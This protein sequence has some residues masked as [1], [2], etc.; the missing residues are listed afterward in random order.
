MSSTTLSTKP[1]IYN[2]HIWKFFY[3]CLLKTC[4]YFNRMN[5]RHNYMKLWGIFQNAGWKNHQEIGLNP[6]PVNF[7]EAA[8]D[9]WNKPFPVH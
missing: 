7:A 8:N 1:E 5:T 2:R 4:R 9:G 6:V 3:C